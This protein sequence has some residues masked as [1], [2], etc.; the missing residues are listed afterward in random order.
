MA[1]QTTN[2]GFTKD[3]I[4]EPYDVLKVNL[5]LDAIDSKIKEKET[6]IGDKANLVTV[7]KTNLVAAI[8]E[9]KE[10]TNNLGAYAK[11]SG[12]NTYTATITGYTLAEGQTVR[13]KFTNANT[14]ASTLNI[15]SLGAKSIVKGN[16]SA[17]S[18][19]NIKAGQICNLVYGGSNFQLLG[20][21]GE[22]GTAI[23]S[24]VLLGKT[25]GT[26]NGLVE[27][28]IPS[29]GA[30]TYTPSTV[31]QTIAAGQHL[32]G[33]QTILGD[34]DLVS[35]NIKAGANIFNVQGKSSVVDT[36]DATIPN[37]N[38]LYSGVS[39]YKNGAKIIGTMAVSGNQSAILTTQGASKVIPLGYTDGGTIT[40]SFANLSAE[41]V[42]SGVNVG[43]VVGALITKDAYF[44]TLLA[45]VANRKLIDA[46]KYQ[47]TVITGL[48][49]RPTFILLTQIMSGA[50]Y[51]VA[52][53]NNGTKNLHSI[54]ALKMYNNSTTAIAA[55]DFLST[56]PTNDGFL[57]NFN[58]GTAGYDYWYPDKDLFWI[59]L[60]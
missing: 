8:N 57:I 25:I 1:T 17:L 45:G 49:F 38:Y 30:Q 52:C 41:N 7:T 23:S 6:Q 31:N 22:Y 56:E 29:K 15:N 13:I 26:D 32:S 53:Y 36:E 48:P 2:Y 35:A 9:V 33:I 46:V 39:V 3:D 47:T 16:G 37:S 10:Q 11:A 58:S 34:S 24:D 43:G 44:G 42:K 21:G 19:G 54:I 55:L 5:N 28:T 27:G 14:D 4:N 40:A 59:A 12:T 18:S 20:E 50:T 51:G 60:P